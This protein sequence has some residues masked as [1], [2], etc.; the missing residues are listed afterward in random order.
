MKER[1]II[2]NTEMVKAILDGRKTQTRRV[3][4]EQPPEGS[5]LCFDSLED[6]QGEGY[7]FQYPKQITQGIIY[8]AI[9]TL[10]PKKPVPLRKNRRS[11]LGPGNLQSWMQ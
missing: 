1:P 11:S 3:I 7:F 8:N 5:I 4:K 2:F 9:F 10:P 6:Y